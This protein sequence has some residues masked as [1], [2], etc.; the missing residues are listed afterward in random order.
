MSATLHVLLETEPHLEGDVADGEADPPACYQLGQVSF[1][2]CF[3]GATSYMDH[4]HVF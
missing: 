2:Q 3:R 4:K 1:M